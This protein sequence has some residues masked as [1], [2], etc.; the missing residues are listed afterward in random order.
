[1]KQKKKKKIL[2]LAG[3]RAVNPQRCDLLLNFPEGK[4]LSF[5]LKYFINFKPA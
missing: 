1:M 5:M 3:S 4:R 2:S